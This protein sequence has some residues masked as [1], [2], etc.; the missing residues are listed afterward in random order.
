[1]KESLKIQTTVNV[2]SKTISTLKTKWHSVTDCHKMG[3]SQPG[4]REE[5][6]LCWRMLCC[7]LINLPVVK[8]H[9]ISIFG[10]SLTQPN[11]Q[12]PQCCGMIP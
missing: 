5:P 9:M 4:A 7:T 10:H 1:M 12:Q 6:F 11:A 2:H 3:K 8:H